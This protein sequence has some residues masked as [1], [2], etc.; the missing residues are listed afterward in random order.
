ML[1]IILFGITMAFTRLAQLVHAVPR[2]HRWV[3]RSLNGDGHLRWKDRPKMGAETVRKTWELG[4]SSG[5]EDVLG[6]DLEFNTYLM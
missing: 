5:E 3:S 4:G 2:V 1:L 6:C